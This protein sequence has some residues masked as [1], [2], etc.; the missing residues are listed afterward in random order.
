MELWMK[1]LYDSS[2][3]AISI[4]QNI[5]ILCLNRNSF[6]MV[7][8]HNQKVCK[9]VRLSFHSKMNSQNAQRKKFRWCIDPE[10]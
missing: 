10:S 3:R 1:F 2:S 6:A 4:S 7:S 9:H 5:L 8:L